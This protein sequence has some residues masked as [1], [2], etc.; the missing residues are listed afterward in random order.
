MFEIERDSPNKIQLKFIQSLREYL[1]KIEINSLREYLGKIKI[2]GLREYL[3]K[4]EIHSLREYL[5]K[6]LKE[7]FSFFQLL[8]QYKFHY[9]YV[10]PAI[11][12]HQKRQKRWITNLW[13][14]PSRNQPQYWN[15]I[16]IHQNTN[17]FCIVH[18]KPFT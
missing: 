8:E 3:G 17:K 16:E 14:I 9:Y 12:T 15:Q 5:G 1:G 7:F 13:K 18:T 4:I 11:R 2:H 10:T 6:K